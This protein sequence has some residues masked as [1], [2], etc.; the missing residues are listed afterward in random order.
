MS[1]EFLNTLASIGTFT[2]IAVT[3]IAA[4][5]QLRHLNRN[6]QLQA[7]IALRAERN[8]SE[9]NQAYEFVVTELQTKLK[10]QTY[11]AELE[12]DLAPSRERH[13]ELLLADFYEHVGAYVKKKLIDED[14]YFE[15]ASP[16][17]YWALVEPAIAI[18]RRKRGAQCFDNFEYLVVREQE[19][20]KAHPR[21]TYPAHERRLELRDPFLDLD[22]PRR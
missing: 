18:Y 1:L 10:D 8:L 22:V 14:V 13:K 9:I 3:A 15:Q 5:I 7:V 12:N 2:V 17:R 21:G 6:N 4:M 19:W 20:E 11:R 16:G